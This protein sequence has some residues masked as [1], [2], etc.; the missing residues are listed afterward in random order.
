MEMNDQ[1]VRNWVVLG[2]SSSHIVQVD[3]LVDFYIVSGILIHTFFMCIMITN[4][5][6][7]ILVSIVFIGKWYFTFLQIIFPDDF[8]N[9]YSVFLL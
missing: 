9:S 4:F 8:Y 1:I 7:R 5:I 6:L 3:T 2:P